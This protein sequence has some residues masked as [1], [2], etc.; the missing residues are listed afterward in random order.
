MLVLGEASKTVEQEPHFSVGETSS[1]LVQDSDDIVLRQANVVKLL[2]SLKLSSPV[3]MTRDMLYFSLSRR[4]PL[5]GKIRV[6]H[7]L[8]S[9]FILFVLESTEA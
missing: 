1:E 9:L 5:K 2:D 8:P 7:L 3:Y 6:S 4:L